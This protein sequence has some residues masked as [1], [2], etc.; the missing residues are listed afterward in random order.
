MFVLA[1]FIWAIAGVIDIALNFC[2]FIIIG[3]VIISWLSVDP[4]NPIVQFFIS[5]TEP[6][7]A[8]IR[9]KIKLKIGMLDISP[10]VVMLVI[11]F[12]KTVLVESLRQYSRTL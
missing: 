12:I 1:N 5:T 6:I 11:Y 10:M 4:Y 3:R 2:L 8:P 9:K 7:L